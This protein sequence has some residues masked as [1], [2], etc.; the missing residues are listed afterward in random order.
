VPLWSGGRRA[1]G[2]D[3]AQA[4]LDRI[5]AL[6]QQ[7]E[8]QVDADVRDADADLAQARAERELAVRARA[9]AQEA[10]RINQ[11]LAQEGRGEPNAV[12]LSEAEIADA[13]E[14]LARAELHVSVATAR[15]LNAEGKLAPQ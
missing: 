4:Q 1:A 3:R 11:L 2:V 9:I 6:R 5:S 10:L 13:D 12:T 8:Q 7:R 14:Q 15:L